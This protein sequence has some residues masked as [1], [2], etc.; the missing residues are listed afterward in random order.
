MI[1]RLQNWANSYQINN[2]L[3]LKL[4]PMVIEGAHRQITE[5]FKCLVLKPLYVANAHKSKKPDGRRPLLRS[6][7]G[8]SLNSVVCMLTTQQEGYLYI[9][10]DNC[11]YNPLS[12][13]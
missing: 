5:E 9:F 6:E 12:P 2:L 4:K 10:C 1:Y 3:Q 8:G 13:P 7:H 11:Q